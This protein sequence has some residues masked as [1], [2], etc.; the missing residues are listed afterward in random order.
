M[1][2]ERTWPVDGRTQL[3]VDAAVKQRFR[4]GFCPECG[5]P[6]VFSKTTPTSKCFRC[7]TRHE[8][9]GVKQHKTSWRRCGLCEKQNMA[10]IAL[11]QRYC[12]DCQSLTRH[13][14]TKRLRWKAERAATIDKPPSETPIDPASSSQE[15]PKDAPLVQNAPTDPEEPV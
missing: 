8:H 15:T 14:R 9:L 6:D 13:E 10:G 3:A 1:M 5:G 7:G 2:A 12:H 4:I 11:T